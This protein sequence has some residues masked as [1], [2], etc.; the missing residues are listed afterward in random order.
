MPDYIG[1]INVELT[2]SLPMSFAETRSFSAQAKGVLAE[3]RDSG[4]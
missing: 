3:D 1:S 4:N 2:T